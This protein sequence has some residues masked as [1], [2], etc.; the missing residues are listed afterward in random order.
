[1]FTQAWFWTTLF[2]FFFN[3]NFNYYQSKGVL[4]GAAIATQDSIAAVSMLGL[5]VFWIIG[6]FVADHWWQPLAAFGI[7]MFGSSI[8]GMITDSVLPRSIAVVLAAVSP[9]LLLG[10][11]IASYLVWY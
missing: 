5:I 11:V 6:L 2:A 8:I 3:S 9:F 1:M 10:L 4:N 7:S